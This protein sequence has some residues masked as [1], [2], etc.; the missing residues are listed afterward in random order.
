M[1]MMRENLLVRKMG[2]VRAMW[3]AIVAASVFGETAASPC[4]TRIVEGPISR[5]EALGVRV[6]ISYNF[7]RQGMDG[8][9]PSVTV[10]TLGTSV[11]QSEVTEEGLLRLESTA[12]AKTTAAPVAPGDGA[13][14]TQEFSAAAL[15][16]VAG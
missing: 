1:M 5:I 10:R 11:D 14:G 3:V 2:L 15:L 9:S 7:V 12:C 8:R 4:Q 13:Q 6:N 16:A